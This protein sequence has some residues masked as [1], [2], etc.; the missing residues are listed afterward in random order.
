[1]KGFE[2]VAAL[3][4][5]E[6][7]LAD[8]RQIVEAAPRYLTPGGLLAVE[9]GIGHHAELSRLAREA[10]FTNIESRQDL[11]HRDRYVLAR[12]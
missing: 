6:D 12:L 10:G 7:G 2:P 1:V 11:T 9:T 5:E 8:L 4:A 3:T